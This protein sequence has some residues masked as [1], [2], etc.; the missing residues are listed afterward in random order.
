MKRELAKFDWTTRLEG[1]D[2]LMREEIR[3]GYGDSTDACIKL[4]GS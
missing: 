1:E 4:T 3:G 2:E